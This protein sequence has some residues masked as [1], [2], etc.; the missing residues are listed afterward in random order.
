M[1]PGSRRTRRRPSRAELRR[2]APARFRFGSGSV[3]AAA[4]GGSSL[5]GTTDGSETAAG[6]VQITGA[7]REE[8]SR[9]SRPRFRR[10]S[11]SRRRRRSTANRWNRKNH[12]RGQDQAT[13]HC[14]LMQAEAQRPARPRSQPSAPDDRC[15]RW[16]QYGD[17]SR[18]PQRG[19]LPERRAPAY[20][21]SDGSF[22]R[23]ALAITQARTS[24]TV[25][26]CAA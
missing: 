8:A 4:F 16:L 23:P 10:S 25:L 14:P 5:I 24:A 26:S 18:R 15:R 13:Q 21:C 22:A 3:Q 6:P 2:G 17:G 7:N 9:R 20:A 19:R 11:S 1:P 12:P